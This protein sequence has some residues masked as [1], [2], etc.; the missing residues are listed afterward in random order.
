MFL[1]LIFS[2]VIHSILSER[3]YSFVFFLNIVIIC[4]GGIAHMKTREDRPCDLTLLITFNL[5]LTMEKYKN[6]QA[7]I[8][9]SGVPPHSFSRSLSNSGVL[10]GFFTVMRVVGVR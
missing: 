10:F 2:S 5:D 3:S 1:P 6:M 8:P 9:L 7:I 4:K